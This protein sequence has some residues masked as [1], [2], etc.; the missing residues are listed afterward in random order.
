[1]NPLRELLAP[2][3]ELL[4]A[5]TALADVPA[6]HAALDPKTRELIALAVN[7]APTHLHTPGIRRHIRAALAHGATREEVMETLQLAATL[8]IHA[9]S[10]GFPLLDDPPEPTEETERLRAEFTRR[11]GYWD[12]SWEDVL[13]HAPVLFAA[14][15]RFSA[16]PWDRNALPP[17]TKELIYIAID[18]SATHM[19]TEGL[20]VHIT[21]AK[22]H[23]A[24]PKEIAATL[25]IASAIVLQTLEVAV[26]ILQEE[27]NNP[28]LK[29][30]SP[31]RPA[32][33]SA[34][35]A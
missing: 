5:C 21:N 13:R 18:A 29:E 11:R 20:K 17:K 2:D 35:E 31:A 25:E 6:N 33:P 30:D 12:P 34:H 32:T 1:M 24:T 10:T 22:T 15:L 9:A 4:D 23:G 27:L 28:P 26:P 19:F 7:A 8:G 3:P 16:I 14:Y